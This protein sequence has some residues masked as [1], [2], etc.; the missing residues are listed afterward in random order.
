DSGLIQKYTE[1]QSKASKKKPSPLK[2][3]EVQSEEGNNIPLEDTKSHEATFEEE[4]EAFFRTYS[5]DLY[6][7]EG[8]MFNKKHIP[9]EELGKE[10][11]DKYGYKLFLEGLEYDDAYINWYSAYRLIE[12]YNEDHKEEILLELAACSV[13]SEF[14]EVKTAANFAMDVLSGQTDVYSRIKRGADGSAIFTRFFETQTGGGQKIYSVKNQF[15]QELLTQDDPKAGV[16]V[17]DMSISPNGH[18]LWVL[19]KNDL[20]YF[21]YVL[22]LETVQYPYRLRNLMTIQGSLGKNYSELANMA[23]SLLNEDGKNTYFMQEEYG[24]ADIQARWTTN[25][26]LE[27]QIAGEIGQGKEWI[28]EK[29]TYTP[30][31]E[32]FIKGYESEKEE[33]DE[34]NTASQ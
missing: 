23:K 3:T 8:E 12:F 14:E 27:V 15:L 10:L 25:E 9:S 29:F 11:V 19:M 18:Y 28:Q 2:E 26:L 30:Q 1:N 4:S 32:A 16:T 13:T 31:T 34:K 5:K 21:A 20:R 33:T 6:T 7:E 24:V 22:P 17:K